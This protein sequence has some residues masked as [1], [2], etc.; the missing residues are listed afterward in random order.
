[1]CFYG[2]FVV[3]YF[4]CCTLHQSFL[5][6][7]ILTLQRQFPS[8]DDRFY[9]SEVTVPDDLNVNQVRD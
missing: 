1:M 9:Y 7:M 5:T 3:L 4:P 6:Y 2:V 8:V